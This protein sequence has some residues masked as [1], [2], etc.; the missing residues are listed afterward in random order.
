MKTLIR[1]M[2]ILL[3]AL[4]VAGAMWGVAQSPV[5]EAMRARME[6]RIAARAP[7]APPPDALDGGFDP[8]ARGGDFDEG[9]PNRGLYLG[10]TV[11][12]IT[13]IGV[14]T[15]LVVTTGLVSGGIKKARRMRQARSTT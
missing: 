5:G 8:A 14:I 4:I 6:S 7:D 9:A 12:N 11:K 15:A 10:N 3:A 1:I 2:V 13:I